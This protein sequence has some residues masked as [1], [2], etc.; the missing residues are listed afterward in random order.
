[1]AGDYTACS[2]FQ[3]LVKDSQ[4][5]QIGTNRFHNLPVAAG[6]GDE[7]SV[8]NGILQNLIH[9]LCVGEDDGTQY[10]TVIFGGIHGTIHQDEPEMK[11]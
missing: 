11:L 6:V 8:G 5:F 1:M 3:N 7:D 4:T 10:S 9:I 2:G